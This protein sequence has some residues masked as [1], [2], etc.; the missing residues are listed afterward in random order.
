MN[1]SHVAK[2]KRDTTVFRERT[3]RNRL[4]LSS[5][6]VSIDV[7]LPGVQ[8][9]GCSVT[10]F[11]TICPF[12]SSCQS[13]LLACRSSSLVTLFSVV[14]QRVSQLRRHHPDTAGEGAVRAA[15]ALQ[16]YA[17]YISQ[18]SKSTTRTAA[19]IF[20]CRDGKLI[21]NAGIP[22]KP[23]LA[24]PTKGVSEVLQRFENAEFTCEFKYDG[25]RAQV[26]CVPSFI[27][28][29]PCHPEEKQFSSL[30][31]EVRCLVPLSKA[32]GLTSNQLALA[33]S[34]FPLVL[35]VS[36]VLLFLRPADSCAG[37]WGGSHLQPQLR[38]QHEQVPGHHR[39]HAQSAQRVG[40]VGRHRLGVCRLG[41][42]EETDPA[43][44]GSQH[45]EEKGASKRVSWT[46]N[47]CLACERCS[48]HT[49]RP[50]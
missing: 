34:F 27:Q 11:I 30:N 33:G 48:P 35:V 28:S 18:S 10:A 7:F 8:R 21:V 2:K 39:A 12:C 38:E 50:A 17:R 22:L 23:M 4:P 36:T 44:P 1:E 19:V 15:K 43:V 5:R 32:L 37:E 13:S 20:L 9:S 42:G 31:Q 49:P 29:L 14:L 47:S 40:Q 16:T 25:E 45:Q 41:P 26:G 3:R 46:K 6:L 24:H